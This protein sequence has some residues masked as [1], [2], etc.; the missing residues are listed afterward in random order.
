MKILAN[1]LAIN[2]DLEN[3]EFVIQE[4]GFQGLNAPKSRGYVYIRC[5]YYS[6]TRNGGLSKIKDKLFG[7]ESILVAEQQL[8]DT[9]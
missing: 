3:S 4:G 8:K 9:V 5:L 2:F 7:G 1:I 6:R